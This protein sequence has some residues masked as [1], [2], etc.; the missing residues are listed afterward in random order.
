METLEQL[1]KD[2]YGSWRG[3]DIKSLILR[4]AR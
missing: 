3:K 1:Y 2:F 4:E